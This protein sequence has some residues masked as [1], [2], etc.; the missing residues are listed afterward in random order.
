[1]ANVFR[2]AC[3][4]L[5]IA[6]CSTVPSPVV[7]EQMKLRCIDCRTLSVQR[8]I[9]GDTFDTPSSRVR[10]FGVD[11]PERGEACFKEATNRLRS[12]AGSQVRVEPGPRAQDRGGRLLFYVYT[13]AGNSIDEILIREGL[14]VAWTRDGQHRDYLV[15][16]ATEAQT[17]GTGCI[18]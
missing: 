5:L 3:M 9:D 15:S 14:A 18:W 10:L 12:L 6:A 1:M 16:L 7:E 4:T 11:T 8:I 17:K 2:L 13:E